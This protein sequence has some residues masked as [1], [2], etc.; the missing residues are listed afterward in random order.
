M[1]RLERRVR[2]GRYE[3]R[4]DQCARWYW[5]LASHVR[6]FHGWPHNAKNPFGGG[7]W[8]PKVVR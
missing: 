3:W 1:T 6:R 5:K 4:C 8:Q 2:S 7:K